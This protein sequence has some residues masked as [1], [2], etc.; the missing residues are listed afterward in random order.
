[1][2]TKLNQA[3]LTPEEKYKIIN[4]KPADEMQLALV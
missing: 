2:I 4:F 1:M 3:N